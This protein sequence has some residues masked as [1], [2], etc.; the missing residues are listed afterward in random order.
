[1]ADLLS[2]SFQFTCPFQLSTVAD[3][4]SNELGARWPLSPNANEFFGCEF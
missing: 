1:L 2:S 4:D 3:E